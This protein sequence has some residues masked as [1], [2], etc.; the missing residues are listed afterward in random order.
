M[1]SSTE[2]R[3]QGMFENLKGK[4]KQIAGIVTDNHELEAKGRAQRLVGKSR[5]K[6]GDIKKVVGK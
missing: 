4:L 1:K 5:E 3:A 6:L 2:D